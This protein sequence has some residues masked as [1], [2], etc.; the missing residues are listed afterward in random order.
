M[1]VKVIPSFLY[2]F[3]YL[4]FLIYQDMTTGYV[5][6]S[7]ETAQRNPGSPI[8]VLLHH[9]MP[10]LLFQVIQFKPSQASLGAT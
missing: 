3:Q 10:V 9:M 2:V 5:G 1:L 8:Q 6:I 4:V 7:G